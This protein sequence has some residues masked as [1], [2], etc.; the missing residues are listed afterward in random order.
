ME[1]WS[2][3]VWRH[4]GV[5]ASLQRMEMFYIS[6]HQ[7]Q[8]GDQCSGVKG[9]PQLGRVTSQ[10]DVKEHR[11]DEVTHKKIKDA[12]PDDQYHYSWKSSSGV[13]LLSHEIRHVCIYLRAA[14][15]IYWFLIESAFRTELLSL[16]SAWT[17]M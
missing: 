2:C 6:E 10:R 13:W 14:V 1:G 8:Q 17:E 16:C 15:D 4:P 3:Y 9:A 5:P 11:E 7:S 12:R